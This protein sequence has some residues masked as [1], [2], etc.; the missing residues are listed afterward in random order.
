MEHPE[1]TQRERLGVP[2]PPRDEQQVCSCGLS[3]GDL[4]ET[5][6]NHLVCEDCGILCEECGALVCPACV[7]K[8]SEGNKLCSDECKTES[9]ERNTA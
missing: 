6:C 7:M 5:V 2:E 1:I 9:E 3:T 4:L 8:D